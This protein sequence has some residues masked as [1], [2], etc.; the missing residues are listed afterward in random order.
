MMY[1]FTANK[2]MVYMLS[3]LTQKGAENL[4]KATSLAKNIWLK[5]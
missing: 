2:F 4:E 5:H 3:D 1:N